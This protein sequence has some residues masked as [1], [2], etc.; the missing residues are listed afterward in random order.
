MENQ[1]NNE[2]YELACDA[3]LCSEHRQ[4]WGEKDKLALIQ[5]YKE[6]PDWC[7]ER[8]YPS[9]EYMSEHFDNEDTREEGVFVNYK[10][11]GDVLSDQVYVFINCTG[12]AHVKFD[13]S[14]AIFPMIYVSQ[15]SNIKFIV[16]GSHTPFQL[17]DDSVIDVD[18]V[19]GGKC[20]IY[21]CDSV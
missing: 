21:K 15:G 2:L 20:K 1:L 10:L 12:V 16:D 7:L 18:V 4:K 14:K 5:Y 9:L 17:Y 6:N 13:A 11:D 19:N 8:Q 3:D